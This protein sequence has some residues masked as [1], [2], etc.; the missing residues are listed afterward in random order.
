MFI[1]APLLGYLGVRR[2]TVGSAPKPKDAAP[3]IAPASSAGAERA[4][5]AARPVVS[6]KAANQ[7]R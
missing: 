5:A 2:D 6:K 7:P 3:V 1:A 4:K